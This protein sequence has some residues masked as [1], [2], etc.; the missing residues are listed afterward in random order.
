MQQF[1]APTRLLD[2]SKSPYVATFFALEEPPNRTPP[3]EA[4]VL[5]AVNQDHLFEELY[6]VAVP[7]E[8]ASDKPNPTT[9]LLSNTHQYFRTLPQLPC[10]VIIPA[11]PSKMNERLANQQGVFL[12]ALPRECRFTRALS[13]VLERRSQRTEDPS[14]YKLQIAPNSRMHLLKELNRMNVN[15]AS[16][17]PGLDGFAR[18][19]NITAETIWRTS[20]GELD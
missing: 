6:Q 12:Y 8:P 5:W 1:G 14:L 7:P 2:W 3:I 15:A 9:F 13:A 20:A 19:L 10:P 17:F 11:E 16:L 4:P 18:S